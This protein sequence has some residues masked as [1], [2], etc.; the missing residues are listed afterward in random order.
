MKLQR[1]VS[2]QR[3]VDHRCRKWDY[4]R[5]RQAGSHVMLRTETPSRDGIS[6]PLHSPLRPGMLAAIVRDV[7][8]HKGVTREDILRDL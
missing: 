3:L 6:V 5:I 4:T 1:S 7:A 8:T 2:G